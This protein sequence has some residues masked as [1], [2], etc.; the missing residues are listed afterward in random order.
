MSVRILLLDD[1]SAPA[2][3]L[4]D[5]LACHAP[6]WQLQVAR[7]L[8]GAGALAA[9]GQ[10]D[11]VLVA[12]ALQEGLPAD[13]PARWERVPVLLWV[14]PGLPAHQALRAGYAQHVLEDLSDA[15]LQALVQGLQ[16][17]LQ[18][19]RAQEALRQSEAR[20][21]SMTQLSSDWFWEQDAELRFVRIEGS[22]HSSLA[23]PL[24]AHYGRRRW[25]LPDARASAAQWQA[26]RAV[27]Q[28]RQ[29]FHGFEFQ[30]HA[31]DG[32]AVWISI[33]GEPLFDAAGQFTGYRGVA[34][35]ITRQKQAE[36]EIQRLAHFDELTG[37]P[38][39]RLLARHLQQALE[40][41]AC[42]ARH[43][44]VLYLDLNDF[45]QVNDALGHGWGDELLR[46]AAARLGT[47]LRADDTV[48]RLG[49]D[50]FVLVLQ[51][52]DAE[53]TQA[54]AQAGAVAQKIQSR[55]SAP[56]V[57]GG[58]QAHAPP[59][60]G[61]VLFQDARDAVPELLRR[62]DTAMYRAKAQG[63]HAPCFF[64]PAMQAQAAA[65][66][67]LEAEL[68]R[69]L[70]QREF[71]LHYQPVVDAAGQ[72][73]GAE[74]LVRWQHPQR[75]LVL[76]GEF[77][78][79]CERS[80]LI[81]PLGQQVL[82]AACAQ[83]VRWAAMPACAHWTLAINVSVC[84]FRHPDFVHLVL[85]ALQQSGADPGLLRLELTESMLLSD[86][87]DSIAKMQALRRQG[88]GL[89]IDD[90]GTGSSS[91]SYLKRLPLD[92]LKI[93]Q[94]FVRGLLTGPN[95]AAIACAV[96][97]LGRS[98]GLEVVAE[99]VE[100]H[101]QRKF[102]LRNGCQRFQGYLFGRPAPAATLPA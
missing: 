46:Q 4:R 15:G 2:Q 81:F 99:G 80:G 93:D 38:N 90:F 12:L 61:M 72:V 7:G 44:A 85:Q 60:I 5:A 66:A 1:R 50:E 95:D 33:S 68:R 16:A 98:L 17:S 3:A 62:A 64:D 97:A 63:G 8:E 35:N 49:G 67:T 71:L 56:Y 40:R 47:C 55:L 87:E 101:A 73:Q 18:G 11:A 75:G 23:V 39:R 37:L 29:P 76:P 102:L 92:Q 42:G 25:E 34:R 54:A 74:A 45:K 53:P 20:W 57:L 83:L 10:A 82:Q 48:A 14:P 36:A 94:G 58:V 79:L 21:R 51:G 22:P 41:C 77:I 96:L 86:V 32:S 30:R 24:E 9:S 31:P 19:Q 84:E 88:V 27:L 70:E 13:L 52:L 91:L 100:S 43:G 59:S 6:G 65:R 26:H 89:S 28:A 78:G 69:G